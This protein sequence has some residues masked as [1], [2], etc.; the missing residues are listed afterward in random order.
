MT[1][2]PKI[3]YLDKLDDMVNEYNIACYRSIKMKSNDV[4][5]DIY[6]VTLIK[7]LMIKTPI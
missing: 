3:V 5:N 4:N 1:S 6:K 2:I 7:K